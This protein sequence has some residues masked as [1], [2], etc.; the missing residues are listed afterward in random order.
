MIITNIRESKQ[1][2]EQLKKRYHRVRRTEKKI[3]LDE[4]TKTTGHER[5]YAI[6]LLTGW[7]Q[8]K[9]GKI[10]RPHKR[11]YSYAD[12]IVLSKVCDVLDWINSKRIQPQ[13]GIAIESLMKTKELNCPTEQKE[14]LIKISP[15]TIDRLLT[16]YR[17]RP[18]GKGRSY[19]KPGTLLRT[20]IPI[21]TFAD[22]NEKKV[23][24]FE[25]D[26]VGHEGGN[27]SGDFAFTLVR[28]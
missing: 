2:L 27:A 15:A 24:F 12:A 23:G 7:Y 13:I 8:Y 6:K 11:I 14:K 10:H 17:K 5:K 21:R 26:L 9:K 4:F 28:I 19:T 22:W 18:V 20:Q 25:I 16:R 1:Y 3:I